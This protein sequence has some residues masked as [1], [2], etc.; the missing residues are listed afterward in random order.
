MFCLFVC[1]PEL[2][3]IFLAGINKVYHG[4]CER[5]AFYIFSRHA[6][7][8]QNLIELCHKQYNNNIEQF[9]TR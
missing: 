5:G 3:Q 7:V 8:I 1:S 6:D 4:Q 2:I 9:K